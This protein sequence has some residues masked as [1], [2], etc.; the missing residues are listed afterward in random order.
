M[1][2]CISP[3][4]FSAL[5][6]LDYFFH[7]SRFLKLD[8]YQIICIRL[9][10]CLLPDFISWFKVTFKKDVRKDTN[11][12]KLLEIFAGASKEECTMPVKC[13]SQCKAGLLPTLSVA[14]D[15]HLPF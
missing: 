6:C 9:H 2:L 4:P 13:A 8:S 10:S 1:C 5:S 14:P 15:G 3:C 7:I 11:F 12:D